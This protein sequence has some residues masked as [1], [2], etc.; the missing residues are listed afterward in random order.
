MRKPRSDSKLKTLPLAKRERIAAWCAEGALGAARAK[1][2]SELGI[3][4]SERALSEFAK[5]Q[6]KDDEL[7]LGNQTAIQALEWWKTNRPEAD[8]DELRTA[9]FFA[10][11]MKANAGDDPELALA[12]LKEQGK[13]LDRGLAARR[14]LVLEAKLS[15]GREVM[16]DKKL[17]PAERE[18]KLREVFGL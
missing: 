15:T 4:T 11:L 12:V 2:K 17:T 9:Q 5:W 8:A 7:R 13:D 3:A 14:V 1:C 18:A 6:K 10:L 16:E